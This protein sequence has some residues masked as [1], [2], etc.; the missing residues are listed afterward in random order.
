M[1]TNVKKESIPPL[2]KVREVARFLS[3]SRQTVHHL[4][5]CGDL[6]ASHVNPHNRAKE[7]KH[8]RVT[9]SSLLSFYEK[10]FGHPLNLAL[11][12]PFEARAS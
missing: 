11:A 5:D 12:N 9:R 10:R 4:I 1:V 2:V 3:C 8:V 7:R 6:K